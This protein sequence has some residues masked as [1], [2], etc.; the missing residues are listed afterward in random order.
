MR[1]FDSD[2][3]LPQYL[4]VFIFSVLYFGPLY[5]WYWDNHRIFINYLYNVWRGGR[6]KEIV[7][8]LGEMSIM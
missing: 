1:S 5:F 4:F 2:K 6:V 3:T 7:S 8:L